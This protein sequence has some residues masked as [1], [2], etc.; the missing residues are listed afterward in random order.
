M[1]FGINETFRQP[2]V[3]QILLQDSPFFLDSDLTTVHVSPSRVLNFMMRF[4]VLMLIDRL[5]T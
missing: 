5:T 3:T 1:L 4:D 2:L